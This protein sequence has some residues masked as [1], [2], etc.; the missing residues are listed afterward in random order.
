MGDEHNDDVEVFVLLGQ[1]DIE[2]LGLMIGT[3]DKHNPLHRSGDPLSIYLL[4]F[5]LFGTLH[6]I[7][8]ILQRN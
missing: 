3:H 4:H 5:E 6:V 1:Q 2:V 7:D 8:G